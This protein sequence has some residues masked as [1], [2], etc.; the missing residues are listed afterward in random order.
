MKWGWICSRIGLREWYVT[1]L[2]ATSPTPPWLEAPDY[3]HQ[4]NLSPVLMACFKGHFE[5]LKW[6]VETKGLE[7]VTDTASVRG[8]GLRVYVDWVWVGSAALSGWCQS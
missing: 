8:Q 6:L 2:C 3:R 1:S 4:H 7:C 5:I